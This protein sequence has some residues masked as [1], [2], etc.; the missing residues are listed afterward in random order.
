MSSEAF[1][2]AWP[3]MKPRR[4]SKLWVEAFAG[5][6]P[7]GLRFPLTVNVCLLLAESSRRLTVN[8]HA[9]AYLGE[10]NCS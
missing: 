9:D 10:R 4:H 3:R 1:E 8:M 6:G 5:D 7:Y 2:P